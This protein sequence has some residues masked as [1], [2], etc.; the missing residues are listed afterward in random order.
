MKEFRGEHTLE[1]L[2]IIK[3][4]IHVH[5]QQRKVGNSVTQVLVELSQQFCFPP[6]T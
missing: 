5:I 1:Q 2:I 4:Y 6:W 3:G